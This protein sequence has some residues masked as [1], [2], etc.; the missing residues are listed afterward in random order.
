MN[1][2]LDALWWKL[3]QPTRPRPRLA[4]DCAAFVAK[5]LRIE[6]AR[7]TGERGFRYLLALDADP[8]PLTDYLAQRAPFDHRLGIY[9]EE[10]LAFWFTNAPHTK[11][12]AYNLTVFQTAKL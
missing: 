3:H 7:T 5:R 11:L 9:A 2:A 6:R 4:A 12:H 8:A 10:L 1:Y